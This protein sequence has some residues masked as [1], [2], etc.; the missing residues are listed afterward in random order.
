[1]GSYSPLA[2]APEGLVDDV[3]ARVAQPVVDL[4]AKRGTPFVGLL[5][6]GLALTSRGLRVVEF[7]VRFGDP[8][9]QV[10]LPRLK[11]PLGQLLL[12]AATGS[13][14][15]AKLDWTKQGAVAVVLAAQGYPAFVRTGDAIEGI[16]AAESVP[17]AHVI[18]A[19]TAIRDGKL[20]AQGGRVLAV[21]GVGEG[22][23][24][25]RETAYQALRAITL[26]GS[27]FR[28]DIAAGME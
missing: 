27:H 6:C 8:E 7:N 2:W 11:T 4:M 15:K 3:V 17:G 10:V 25:A 28:T 14:P 1:M 26:E 19:G 22:I 13:L 21:V 20:V 24:G 9:T 18:Q 23:S 5:Y 16:A 12:A